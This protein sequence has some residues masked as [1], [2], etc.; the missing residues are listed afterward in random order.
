MRSRAAEPR[1]LSPL[2]IFPVIFVILF[3]LHAPLL[4]LPFFWDEAG[5]YVPAAYDLAHSHTLVP[6]TTMDTGH[7]PLPA[8]YLAFWFSLSGWKPAVA[9]AGQ[10]LLA[11]FALT[12][13]FFLARGLAGTG[14]AVASTI[15]TALYPIFF[16]QSSL[17]HADVA[18]AA[19]TLWGIRVSVEKHVW[20]GQF[21]FSLAVL[22]KETAIITPL[23]LALW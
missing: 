14:V 11:A 16:V 1:Q 13:V 2:H 7:P 10:L 8:A 9:R 23:A 19:F 12:N 20:R 17:A 3:L 18:A 5:F 6:T 21:A 4:R 22:S 15:G